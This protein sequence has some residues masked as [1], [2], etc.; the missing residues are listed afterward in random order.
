MRPSPRRRPA[1]R[2]QQ[3]VA[4]ASTLFAT[5]GFAQVAIADIASDVAIAPSALYRHFPTKQALLREVVGQAI[6]GVGT[7]TAAPDLDT[8]ISR[9]AHGAATARY[10]AVLWQRE[11]RNLGA[12]D[13]ALLRADL[14][15]A[16]ADLA[17]LVSTTRPAIA[18]DDATL[19]AWA[20]LAVFGSTGMHRASLP[21]ND[22][23]AQLESSAHLVCGVELA[24]TASS[25]TT[26]A[27]PLADAALHSTREALLAQAIRLFSA[28]GYAA[29]STKDIG[30]AAGTSGPNIYKHFPSKA[31]ILGA[32]AI[33]A[34]EA[35]RRGVVE[36]L[37]GVD[38]PAARLTRLLH[39]HIAFA[40]EQRDLMSVLTG[41]LHQLP[42]PQRR[43]AR[44]GQRDYLKLWVATL[45][46]VR[47][48][49]DAA[50]ARIIA[51]AALAVADDASRTGQVAARPDL[52]DR[53]AEIS[54]AVL[55]IT[56][57]D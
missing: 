26:V 30:A 52:A 7:V 50:H 22:F 39:A 29:V 57:R 40:V 54:G 15:G 31:D 13:R 18:H 36:A 14:L 16:T 24:P 2:R 32:I 43:A 55:G 19:L 33:R 9:G 27:P 11:A 41:E 21:R 23:V 20:T 28:H 8:A 6:A 3:I 1:D 12:A 34:G 47:T 56:P 53:L 44:Q 35:R 17:T 37:G 49:L 46:D 10:A 42:E 51:P 38:D 4:A 48:D 25:R 5:R 45:L